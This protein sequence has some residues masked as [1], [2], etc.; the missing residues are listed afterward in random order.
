MYEPRRS[1][2]A[3]SGLETDAATLASLQ[4]APRR[5]AQSRLTTTAFKMAPASLSVAL[6]AT[7]GALV[8]NNR[9]TPTVELLAVPDRGEQISRSDAVREAL[10]QRAIGQGAAQGEADELAPVAAAWS[11]QFGAVTGTMYTQSAVTV[12]AQAKD[13]GAAMTELAA[14]AAVDTTDIVANGYRQVVIDKKL[15]WIAEGQLGQAA[16]KAKQPEKAPAKQVAPKQAK[17]KNAPA[18]K[19]QPAPKQAPAPKYKG[20]SKLG[21]KPKAMVVY[22]AVM[23]KFNVPNVGGYRSSSRSSHQCGMAIDFMT[24]KN[25]G[26]GDGIANYLVANAGS[27]GVTHII[28]KQRIWTPYRPYWRPMAD[29]GGITAN[30]YDH[31]HVAMADRC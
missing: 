5:A 20:P 4:H 28:W 12:R 31:V 13:D 15:G 8:V 18:P 14:G 26:L 2:E 25:F 9:P 6:L 10:P 16:P 30:H 29:R 19:S 11:S 22:N 23:A 17:S 1:L 21:L 7:A 3:G 24:Y 27:F